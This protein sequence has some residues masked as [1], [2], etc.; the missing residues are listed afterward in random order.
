MSLRLGKSLHG[1]RAQPERE[2]LAQYEGERWEHGECERL[3]GPG[4]EADA[5]DEEL[6]GLSDPSGHHASN[7]LSAGTGS[8]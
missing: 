1:V 5:H 6:G 8:A 4:L 2:A 7:G 3:R